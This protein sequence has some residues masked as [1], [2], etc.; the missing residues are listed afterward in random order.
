MMFEYAFG[1]MEEG[2]VIR[3]AVAA[4]LEAGYVTEDLSSGGA[5][6]STDQVGDWIANKIETL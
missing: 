5:S 2:K 3:K 4:S 1:L 6:Y